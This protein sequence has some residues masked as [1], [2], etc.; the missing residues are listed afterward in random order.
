M[1]H[2][3][4]KRY[5]AAAGA[6]DEEHFYLPAEA[7]Q[8]LKDAPGA[9]FDETVEIAFN[10]GVDP[11]K[12]DQIVRGTLTLP[13]GTGKKV[14][15]AVFADSEGAQ[16]AQD[17]AALVYACA[18]ALEATRDQEFA[19]AAD[20]MLQRLERDCWDKEHGGYTDRVPP[21][22]TARWLS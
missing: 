2:G 22:K 14:R 8:I 16:L 7:L 21:A 9:K 18:V 17:A 3:S 19:R 12:A 13:H 15:I 11:R 5:K 10:L 4:G 1:S 6:V 20:S